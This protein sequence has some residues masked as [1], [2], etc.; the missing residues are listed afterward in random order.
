MDSGMNV[1]TALHKC[2]LLQ[3]PLHSGVH[4]QHQCSCHA[5]P[6]AHVF[7]GQ[8][9]ELLRCCNAVHS[10]VF[11]CSWPLASRYTD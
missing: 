9:T 11:R 8:C 2:P 3:Q 4:Q 1:G 7:A 10:Y 6:V 5:F